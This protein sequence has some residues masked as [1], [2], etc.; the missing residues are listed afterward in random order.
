LEYA[1][2]TVP[3]SAGFYQSVAAALVSIPDDIH[4]FLHGEGVRLRLG[5]LLTQMNPALAGINPPGFPPGSSYDETNGCYDPATR[6]ICISEL[7]VAAGATAGT[8]AQVR[9]GTEVECAVREELGHALDFALDT[10]GG[11]PSQADLAFLA[12]YQ[13]DVAQVSDPGDLAAL[14]YLLQGGGRGAEETFAAL[15]AIMYGGYSLNAS[16]NR[17]VEQSFGRSLQI[18]RSIVPIPRVP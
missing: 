3:C 2:H 14:D 15:F 1:E 10:G 11:R 12:A 6:L 13:A 16:Y 4:S 18:V 9:S 8:P 17:L 5:N 7:R